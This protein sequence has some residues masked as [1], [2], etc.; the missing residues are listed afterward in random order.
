M[1][2]GTLYFLFNSYQSSIGSTNESPETSEGL[3][4]PITILRFQWSRVS[5]PIVSCLSPRPSLKLLKTQGKLRNWF[6]TGRVHTHL[7]RVATLSW[8]FFF[9]FFFQ[10]PS[11]GVS[12]VSGPFSRT[13]VVGLSFWIIEYPLV[14]LASLHE[15]ESSS[16]FRFTTRPEQIIYDFHSRF[17]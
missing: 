15:I 10:F 7:T 1:S 14:H 9:F 16:Y 12:R 2:L 17:S 4:S 8:C 5:Y 13:R 11:L 3:N 6:T